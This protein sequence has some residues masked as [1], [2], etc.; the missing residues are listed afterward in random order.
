[1]KN[2]G[3][4]CDA[5]IGAKPIYLWLRNNTF[6]SIMELPR[7]NGKRRYKRLSLYTNN[8]YEAREKIKQMDNVDTYSFQSKQDVKKQMQQES[9]VFNTVLSN[10]ED[11]ESPL[12]DTYQVKVKDVTKNFKIY[13]DK[14]KMLKERLLFRKRNRHEVREVLKGVSFEIKKGDC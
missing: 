3:A 1:M 9:E 12:K 4:K 7:V 10:W 8:Y 5:K 14:G 2:C 13:L 11:D 6:Y